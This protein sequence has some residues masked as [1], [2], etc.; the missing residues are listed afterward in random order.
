MPDITNQQLLDALTDQLGIITENMVTRDDVQKIVRE[1]TKGF[2][3]KDDLK[4]FVTKD[5]LKDIERR[6]AT[7]D[8]L[9]S[10]VTRLE[11]KISSNHTVNIKHH[12]ETR[13][14]IGD[15]NRKFDHL[16]EGLA[17]AANPI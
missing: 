6:M 8:D 4:A 10:A 15:L 3:T 11:R 17:S 1:E 7:K 16:R 13:K 14:A 12:L 2:A 5:D 9:N